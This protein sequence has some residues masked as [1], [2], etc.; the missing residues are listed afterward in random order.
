[1]GYISFNKVKL[2]AEDHPEIIIDGSRSNPRYVSCV[3]AKLTRN[4]KSS[5]ATRITT[6]PLQLVYTNLAVPMKTT[7]LRGG[8]Y[9]L[10]FIDDYLRNIMVYAFRQKS[11][12]FAKFREYK[13][14]VENYH[15]HKI[16]ALRSENGGE[17]TSH[18]FAKFLR[19]SGI[20]HEKT[21]PYSLEQNAVTE[22]A[23]RT[24]VDRVKDE[25]LNG[26]MSDNLW[27]EA[28]HTAVYLHNWSPT[29]AK[30]SVVHEP[31]GLKPDSSRACSSPS[32]P[33]VPRARAG[34]SPVWTRLER[35]RVSW[36]A[37][38][39]RLEQGSTSRL[40]SLGGSSRLGQGSTSRLDSRLEP[41]GAVL[42]DSWRLEPGSSPRVQGPLRLE[43][44]SP[45]VPRAGS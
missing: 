25:I 7:S 4:P 33:G 43:P 40:E 6:T 8:R 35:T 41:L 29:S 22:K 34:S 30:N 2:L 3:S 10:L 28:I 19:D 32:S 24:L 11:E 17:Y 38:S 9:Y 20:S 16:K 1:M 45:G 13:A 5:P 39:W 14:M 27:A 44:S 23:N 26:N 37:A 12:T 15:D 31:S 42:A 18:Q 36:Q 21:A